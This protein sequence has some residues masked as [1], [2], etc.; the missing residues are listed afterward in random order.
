LATFGFTMLHWRG[1]DLRRR[2][3]DAFLHFR[4]DWPDESIAAAGHGLDPTVGAGGLAEHSAQ[5][6]D[7]N[8]KVAFLYCLAGPRGL[9]QRVLRNQ[10]A[11]PFNQCPQQGDRP[12]TE[13]CGLA[14]AEQQVVLRV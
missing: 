14:S 6:R 11:G 5:G 2:R 3:H 10:C 9:D 13:R 4:D 7:L 8:R 12:P 1:V